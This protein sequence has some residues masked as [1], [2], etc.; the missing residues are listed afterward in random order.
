M[1]AGPTYLFRTRTDAAKWRIARDCRNLPIREVLTD[2]Q[3]RWRLTSGSLRDIVL[4]DRPFE[5]FPDHR[6]P[7]AP[8][9]AFLA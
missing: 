2:A 9:H 8:N 3:V 6:H 7:P 1:P 5:I 4:A